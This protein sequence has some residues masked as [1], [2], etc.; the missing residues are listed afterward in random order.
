MP[1]IPRLLQAVA[2]SSHSTDPNLLSERH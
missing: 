2:G 1:P